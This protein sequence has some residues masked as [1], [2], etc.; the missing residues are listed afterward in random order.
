VANAAQT[1]LDS[2]GI[3]DACETDDTDADGFLDGVEL[4]VGTDPVAACPGQPPHDAWPLDINVDGRVTVVGDV[5]AYAGRMGANGGP[6][7]SSNWSQRLDLN[8]DN[9]ISVVG[10]V[11]KFAGKIGATCN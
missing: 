2:D 1:D 5:L 9:S 4:H 3:G 10:D 8:V 11:L 6:L 7:P